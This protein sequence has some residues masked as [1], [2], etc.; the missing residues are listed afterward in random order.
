MSTFLIPPTHHPA[1]RHNKRFT[2]KDAK[3]LKFNVLSFHP[4]YSH[5][6]LETIIHYSNPHTSTAT[7]IHRSRCHPTPSQHYHT[8]LA[9]TKRKEKTSAIKATV[10]NQSILFTSSAQKT[11]LQSPSMS[12]MP[13]LV[14]ATNAQLVTCSKIKGCFGRVVV[15]VL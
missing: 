12:K 10:M 9:R 5:V 6:P 7:S 14:C 4:T 3:H 1:S 15:I 2:H 11:K 8:T 13:M